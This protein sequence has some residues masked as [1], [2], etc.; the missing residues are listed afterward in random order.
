[1]WGTHCKCSSE[2]TWQF[3]RHELLQGL[4]TFSISIYKK[5]RFDSH[6]ILMYSFS[7]IPVTRNLICQNLNVNWNLVHE[8]NFAQL[9]KFLK[10]KTEAGSLWNYEKLKLWRFCEI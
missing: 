2:T 7:W 10:I 5:S 3:P 1:M 4:V 8:F 9:D 6:N